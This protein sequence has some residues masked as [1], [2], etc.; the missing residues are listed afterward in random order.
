[1]DKIEE[2]KNPYDCSVCDSEDCRGCGKNAWQTGLDRARN[3]FEVK[4]EDLAK[5][6]NCGSIW[7]CWNWIHSNL[8]DLIRLNP[9]L[10]R[11]ELDDSLWGHEC[12][13]CDSIHETKEEVKNGLPYDFLKAYYKPQ[14]KKEHIK[15][16]LEACGFRIE[17]IEG[18]ER[19]VMLVYPDGL[20]VRINKGD[21][22]NTD[23]L[24]FIGFLFK[25][26][27]PKLQDGTL[28][29]ID[30][31]PPFSK[32][33]NWLVSL[34]YSRMAFETVTAKSNDPALA[35]FWALYKVLVENK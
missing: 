21:Y 32:K 18:Y 31:T 3:L 7:V 4:A 8:D 19:E 34:G 20:K 13:D 24:E 22:L 15:K 17:P 35:L 5:C 27:V 30:F 29:S 26:A 25:Y 9:H 2:V 33:R 16:L 11:G 1:M 23:S 14:V 12:W 6:P 10:T 28:V